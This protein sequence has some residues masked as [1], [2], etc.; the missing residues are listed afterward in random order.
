MTCDYQ[1]A[2]IQDKIETFDHDDV[3]QLNNCFTFYFYYKIIV[4]SVKVIRFS[5]LMSLLPQGTD[6]VSALRS[7]QQVAVLVQGCWVV[8]R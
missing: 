8:K 3:N 5:Q 4:V 2:H 1:I 7:V 6:T